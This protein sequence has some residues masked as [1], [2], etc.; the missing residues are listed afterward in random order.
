MAEQPFQ[1]GRREIGI[2]HQPGRLADRGRRALPD[3]CPATLRTAPVLPDDGVMDRPAG[4]AVP[5][6]RGFPLVDDADGGDGEAPALRFGD[7]LPRGFQHGAPDVL[8]ILL[9]P[10]VAREMLGQRLLRTG[11][12]APAQVEGDGPAARR[13]L[14]DRQDRGA[15]RSGG[16]VRRQVCPAPTASS[17]RRRCSGRCADD[18]G[19]TGRS[20]RRSS[21]GP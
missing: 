16:H 19:S 5:D 6:D 17:A 18:P 14:V 11:D 7:C 21:A 13:A 8:R 4:P 2:G 3:Q 12:D 1:L 10:T 20:P 15:G 9:D